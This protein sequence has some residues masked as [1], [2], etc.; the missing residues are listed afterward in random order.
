[1]GTP[2]EVGDSWT[3][4]EGVPDAGADRAGHPEISEGVGSDHHARGRRRAG[5]QPPLWP[6]SGAA[7]GG[8][9]AASSGLQRSRRRTARQAGQRGG[10]ANLQRD[11]VESEPE[12]DEDE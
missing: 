10:G 8:A 4:P 2:L 6:P 3:A 5:A 11:D 9:V 1:M 12:G 7:P